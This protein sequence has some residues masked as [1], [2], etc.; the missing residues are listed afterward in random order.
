MTIDFELLDDAVRDAET[1]ANGIVHNQATW[2]SA[3]EYDPETDEPCGTAMCLAGRI[4]LLAGAKLPP[5]PDRV[6]FVNP[7]TGESEWVNW[8]PRHQRVHI[9]TF[10]RRRAG[11]TEGQA[12]ALFEGS[13]TL[14]EIRAMVDHLRD[15][16][17]SG[18]VE[19]HQARVVLRSTVAAGLGD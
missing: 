9:A 4:G 14:P 1:D 17:E 6:W 15:Y 16:P 3:A 5:S 19:L 11:L 8:D 2:I 13:N 7:V 10:A 18:Y 12:D